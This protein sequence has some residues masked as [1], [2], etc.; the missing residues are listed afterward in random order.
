[1]GAEGR[2]SEDAGAKNSSENARM[3][4]PREEEAREVV[5]VEKA[6]SMSDA[7]RESVLKASVSESEAII[8]FSETVGK[9]AAVFKNRQLVS[10][11]FCITWKTMKEWN[12][13]VNF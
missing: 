12:V 8:V 1:M 4:A 6:E 10:P 3:V 9:D 7:G 11:R 13:D 2:S 5:V